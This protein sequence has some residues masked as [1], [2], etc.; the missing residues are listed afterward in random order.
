MQNYE[1]LTTGFSVLDNSLEHTPCNK[2]TMISKKN[3]KGKINKTKTTIKTCSIPPYG[4]QKLNLKK[5]GVN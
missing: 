3:W 2:V 1:M 4:C 5:I